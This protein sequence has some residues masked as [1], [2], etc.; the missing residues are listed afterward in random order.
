M[1]NPVTFEAMLCLHSHY[2][3]GE[4]RHIVIFELS[5]QRIPMD[6]VGYLETDECIDNDGEVFE[7]FPLDETVTAKLTMEY[8]D[9][10]PS[11][12]M[13]PGWMVANAERIDHE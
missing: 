3:T 12:G 10:D 9:G 2:K 1:A 11:V 5:G 13:W 6:A 7:A 8:E 4:L